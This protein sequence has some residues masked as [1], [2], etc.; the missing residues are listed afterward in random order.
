MRKTQLAIAAFEDGRRLRAKEHGQPRET[1]KW[2]MNP[3]LDP[4]GRRTQ[5]SRQLDFSSGRLIFDF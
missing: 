3:L 5:P 4:P 2:N 1:G